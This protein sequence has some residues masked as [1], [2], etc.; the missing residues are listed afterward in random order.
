MTGPSPTRVAVERRSAVLLVWLRSLP[1]AVPA[2]VVVAVAAVGI[3][4]TGPLSVVALLL[5]LLALTWLAY[6]SWPALAAGGRV[7]RALT[8]GLLVAA[9][10]SRVLA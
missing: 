3:L 4:G 8:L 7:V 1:R 6:L 5:V 10:A 2:L 9:I